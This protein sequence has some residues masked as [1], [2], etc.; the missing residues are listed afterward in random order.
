MS[1][2]LSPY[3]R[4]ALHRSK[5]SVTPKLVKKVL[6][7]SPKVRHLLPP[8]CQAAHRVRNADGSVTRS[9]DTS[10]DTDK[11]IFDENAG[12]HLPSV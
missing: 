2:I 3:H 11:G 1:V 6:R 12:N 7:S 4:R 9:L 8:M 10:V 5:R